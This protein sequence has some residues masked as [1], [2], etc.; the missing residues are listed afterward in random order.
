MYLDGIY[1]I[2]MWHTVRLNG[3]IDMVGILQGITSCW[4]KRTCSDSITLLRLQS[5]GKGDRYGKEK[6]PFMRL[7]IEILMLYFDVPVTKFLFLK[8]SFLLNYRD[9]YL[10][11]QISSIKYNVKIEFFVT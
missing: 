7:R 2:S 9:F 10:Y 6:I 1:C 5:Y 8:V 11:G 4:G 3:L